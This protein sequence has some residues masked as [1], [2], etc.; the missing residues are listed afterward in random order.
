[1]IQVCDVVQC[2]KGLCS[3][4]CATVQ[5]CLGPCANAKSG[6]ELVYGMPAH[7]A[8]REGGFL[9]HNIDRLKKR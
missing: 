6:S 8:V 9:M 4:M 7:D 2:C 5:A 3:A 1:M